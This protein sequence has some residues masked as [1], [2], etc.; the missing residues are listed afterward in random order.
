M[1]K[2]I[3][4]YGGIKV[5]EIMMVEQRFWHKRK[6]GRRQRYWHRFLKGVYKRSQGR[7]KFTGGGKDLSEL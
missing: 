5:K 1:V 3:S 7:F 6:D 4:V 2:R